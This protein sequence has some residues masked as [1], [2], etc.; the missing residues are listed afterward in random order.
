VTYTYS[1]V[2]AGS[3]YTWNVPPGSTIVSSGP[4]TV[5][6]NF[7]SNPGNVSLT[8][9]NPLGN[10]TTDLPI[11]IGATGIQYGLGTDSYEAYPSPFE[12]VANL[13]I[14]S[15]ETAPMKVKV[16]DSKGVVIY[17]TN[18]FFTNQNVTIGKEFAV[19]IYYVE[20]SYENKTQIIKL[21][22]M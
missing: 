12:E 10:H 11:T 18:E 17:A 16:M 13:K 5:T 3:V 8:E 2:N 9:T 20:I 15:A 1:P 19:G 7:G 22:K 4:G 14:N 6:I 21:V